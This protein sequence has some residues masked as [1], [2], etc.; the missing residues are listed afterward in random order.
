M[1]VFP[2][3]FMQKFRHKEVILM[4][5]DNI[6][7]RFFSDN[8]MQMIPLGTQSTAISV[9]ERILEQI[10]EE[11]PNATISELFSTDE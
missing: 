11:N 9:V 3:F 2:S 7:E 5:S 1:T 10:K 8:E 4:F 6:L